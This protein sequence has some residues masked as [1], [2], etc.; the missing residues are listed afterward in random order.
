[1]PNLNTMPKRLS[2]HLFSFSLLVPSRVTLKFELQRSLLWRNTFIAGLKSEHV[3]ILDAIYE[4]DT[5][6]D[7]LVYFVHMHRHNQV[8]VY[9][10]IYPIFVKVLVN[11]SRDNGVKLRRTSE[12]ICL[13]NS[14]D[15]GGYSWKLWEVVW[16][17]FRATLPCISPN[18]VLF[19]PLYFRPDAELIALFCAILIKCGHAD[20]FS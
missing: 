2:V 1:M 8:F 10:L 11:C 20:A 5:W 14:K 7:L 9:K 16:G 18:H 17:L 3:N 19:F 13:Y 4:S 15:R 12:H 6:L